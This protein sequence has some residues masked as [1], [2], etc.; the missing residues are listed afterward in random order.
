MF[1]H[2]PQRY[3]VMTGLLI[4]L[5]TLLKTPVQASVGSCAVFPPNNAWNRDISADPLDPNSSNYIN[6]IGAATHLHPDFG[7][8]PTYGIPYTVVA[9]T[10]PLV[11]I[12]FTEFGN[13]SDPGPY[14][15]PSNAPVEAGSDAHVLVVDKDHCM[16]YELYHASRS[17]SG[18]DAGSGAVYDLASNQLRPDGWTSADAAGLP[19][20]PGLVRY[21]EIQSGVINHA[22]RFTVNNTQRRYIHPATHYASS[23]TNPNYPPMG[24][25][26]RLK[27]S[28]DISG[29]TGASQIVLTALKKYGMI[30][31]DNGSDWFISGATDGR[32]NDNDLNQLKTVP[33]GMFEVV[34]SISP[35]SAPA[36]TLGV[37]RPST[38]TFYLSNSNAN[39]TASIGFSIGGAGAVPIAGDWDGDG[40]D[41]VGLYYQNT[42]MFALYDSNTASAPVTQ[43][44]VFGRPG[45]MPLS[46]RWVTALQNDPIGNMGKIHD[47]VGVFRPSNGLIYLIS[48]WPQPPNLTVFSDY[49]IVLGNPGWRGLA[50]K[51]TGGILDTA[52]VFRPD[53]AR[54]YMTSQS[55]NG[56]APGPGVFCIQYA[57]HDVYMGS[58]NDIPL[59]GDWIGSGMDGI[60]VYRPTTSMFYLKNSFPA[61]TQYIAPPDSSAVFG[62]PGDIPLAGH[63]KQP[64]SVP[65]PNSSIILVSATVPALAPGVA[66]TTQPISEGSGSFD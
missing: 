1:F 55:C 49:A 15:I 19:I 51:W 37:Y 2:R 54:F 21:D 46:G 25:R 44:F 45:D 5:F 6:S 14:P 53:T 3:V 56:T 16:L 63:W 29:F 31:A 27:A 9:G 39:P 12:N 41:T 17:T 40:Y 20:F 26:L 57:S 34:Q 62:G 33:G 61:G 7:S 52:A 35:S 10:Q 13:Q 32:W 58:P 59:N 4:G 47:G 48:A 11:P 18:W 30:V 66:P 42:G 38:R 50:G 24:L 28:Y 8:D 43:N 64:G 36:D 65:P 60:A 22:L 23:S